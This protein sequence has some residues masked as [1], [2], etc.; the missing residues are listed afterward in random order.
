VSIALIGYRGSGKTTVGRR[1]A[2][3]LWQPFVDTDEMIVAKAGKTIADIF[4]QHGE[5]RFR[6]L[7]SEVIR[8]VSA[9]NEHVIALGGGALNR[10]EN[11]AAIKSAGHKLIYLKCEPKE[12]FN[13]IK[14]DPQTAATRPNLTTLGGG[15]EEISK[16]LAEREPI[17]RQAMHAE[18]DVTNLTPDEAVVYIVRLL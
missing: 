18:L 16:V 11:L 7:E 10:P 9:L 3:K 12:L 8:E 6:D 4:E 13:R 17:Y 1:L 2:D 14:S 5:T 15:V